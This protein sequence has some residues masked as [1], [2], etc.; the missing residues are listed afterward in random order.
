MIF[1]AVRATNRKPLV[2]FV[3]AVEAVISRTETKSGRMTAELSAW[4]IKPELRGKMC[5]YSCL[6][7]LT[8]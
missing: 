1:N 7:G 8:L 5:I 3:L 4:L 6:A 2:S